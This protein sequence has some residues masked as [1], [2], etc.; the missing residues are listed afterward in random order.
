M[1]HSDANDECS[2]EELLR[3][4]A[5]TRKLLAEERQR[6]RALQQELT[7][8]AVAAGWRDG[9]IQHLARQLTA[10]EE[11]ERKRLAETLHDDLQQLLTAIK[12]HIQSLQQ[13]Y[14]GQWAAQPSL[15]R[16]TRLI[17]E[18]LLKARLLIQELHPLVLAHLSLAETL[19]SLGTRLLADHGLQVRVRQE[20][21]WR[22][23]EEPP[24]RAFLYRCV[25]ELLLNV[26][27]HAQS[28]SAHVSLRTEG[29]LLKVV[30]SDAGKGFDPRR[31]AVT[32]RPG[33]GLGLAA[34]QERIHCLGGSVQIRSRPTM[35]T[36]IVLLLPDSGAK[37]S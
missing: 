26:A 29:R 1:N 16:I 31:L 36:Q 37:E 24:M 27:K 13:V 3:E 32:R 33:T 12:F 10:T 5:E 23:P 17:D 18:T 34:I 4:L 30:V 8:Q 7:H 11:L 20:K 15:E 6:S 2:R 25:Q 28:R 14:E 22:E 9:Q 19:T 21:T 35:G